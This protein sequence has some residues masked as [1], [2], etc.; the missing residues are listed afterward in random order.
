MI[1]LTDTRSLPFQ[2]D[3]RIRDHLEAV[4]G[5]GVNV[6]GV[7]PAMA[8]QTIQLPMFQSTSQPINMLC[9]LVANVQG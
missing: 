7:V 8:P 5:S 3:G 2:G 6:A 9:F 4:G 1:T